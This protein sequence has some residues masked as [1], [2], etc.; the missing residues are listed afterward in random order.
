[1]PPTNLL[2]QGDPA[3]RPE[4]QADA[5]APFKPSDG[6]GDSGLSDAQPSRRTEERPGFDDADEHLHRSQPIHVIPLRNA[7]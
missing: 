3:R 7:R 5:E 6:L 1:M 4:Q 2:S